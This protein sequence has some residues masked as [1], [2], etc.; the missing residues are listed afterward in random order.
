MTQ[1]EMVVELAERHGLSQ[2]QTTDL[3]KDAFEMIVGAVENKDSIRLPNLGTFEFKV[4]SER[5][6]RNPQTKKTMV[7]PAQG[8]IKF[9]PA[10][11]VKARMKAVK[12]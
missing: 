6:G 12:L 4:A 1:K 3:L 10:A 7:I 9:K 11:P 2:K 8:Q 5:Q